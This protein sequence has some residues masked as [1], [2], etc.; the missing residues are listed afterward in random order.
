MTFSHLADAFIQ[1]R[2]IGVNIQ[3]HASI[4]DFSYRDRWMYELHYY[5]DNREQIKSGSSNGILVSL[6]C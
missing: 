1:M 6:N 4:Y 2:T 3:D 5:M